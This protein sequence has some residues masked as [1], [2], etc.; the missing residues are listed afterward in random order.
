MDP[1]PPPPLRR[2]N[3]SGSLPPQLPRVMNRPRIPSPQRVFGAN[4]P[5]PPPPRLQRAVAPPMHLSV[6]E[7]KGILMDDLSTASVRRVLPDIQALSPSPRT[8]LMNE[9]KAAKI[10]PPEVEQ[11]L[12]KMKKSKRRKLKKAVSRKHKRKL[13]VN[14]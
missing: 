10:I 12:G 9:L 8:H 4:E 3:N 7:I 6:Q 2:S 1:P 13:T 14:R 5:L 11:M